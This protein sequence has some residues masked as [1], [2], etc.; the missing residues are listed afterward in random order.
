MDLTKMFMS[1]LEKLGFGLAY[2]IALELVWVPT[3]ANPADAPSRSK[4]I[5]SWYASLPKLPPAP[6]AFFASVDGGGDT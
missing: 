3:W 4:P 5:E 1:C 2:D 6:I